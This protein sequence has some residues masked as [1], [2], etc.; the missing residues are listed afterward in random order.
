MNIPDKTIVIGAGIAG[1]SAALKLKSRGVNV[2]LFEQSSQVG[3][4]LRT[5]KQDGYLLELGPNTFLNSSE[6]LWRL[7]ESVGLEKEKITAEPKTG[8]KRFIFAGEKLHVVPAGPKILFSSVMSMGGRLRLLKEPFVRPFEINPKVPQYDEPLAMFVRR[9]FGSEALE[10]LVTPFVSGIYAGDPEKLSLKAVFPRLGQIEEKYGS[11][12]KGMRELKGEIK[13]SGLGSFRGGMG[14]LIKAVES[15]LAGEIIKNARVT[16]VEP[17]NGAY[18][19]KYEQDGELKKTLVKRLI[20]A[21]PAYAASRILSGF[22]DELSELLSGIKYA[23]VVVVHT[24]FK[25]KDVRHALNGFG[26]L[27]PRGE[28]V[29][30]LGSLWTSSLFPNRAPDGNVL[31]TNFLG[32]CLDPEAIDLTNDDI[33]RVLSQDLLK[34]LYIKSSPN[35]ACITRYSHAIAQYNVGHIRRINRIKELVEKFEGLYLTGSYFTG[36][37]VASTIEHAEKTAT[38]FPQS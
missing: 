28:R 5:L 17:L 14:D 6:S 21:V 2:S 30:L 29:R 22:S 4:Y 26:C 27:V 7:A 13:S 32:G 38:S 37:S 34:L 25:K 15:N 12:L 20:C 8:K 36:I 31:L 18:L 16:D 24:G 11:V 3:G 35:F 9:R 10:K 1:L 33:M 23:P 19:V